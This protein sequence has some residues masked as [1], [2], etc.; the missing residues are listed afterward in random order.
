MTRPQCEP[1]ERHYG[2]LPPRPDHIPRRADTCFRADGRALISLWQLARRG[3]RP[4]CRHSAIACA[5]RSNSGPHQDS[6]RPK[7]QRPPKEET[8]WPR[9]RTTRQ[10]HRTAPRTCQRTDPVQS[11]R[12]AH[13]GLRDRF[14][15]SHSCLDLHVHRHGSAGGGLPRQTGPPGGRCRA[16]ASPSQWRGP[17][18]EVRP[19]LQ[20]NRW[21]GARA[22]CTTTPRPSFQSWR[23]QGTPPVDSPTWMPVPTSSRTM[24]IS[25]RSRCVGPSA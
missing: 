23:R 13:R 19:Q 25:P 10:R 15:N 21:S 5:T 9:R 1:A 16:R 24:A 14:W 18:H 3:P 2:P 6:G 22:L 4:L 8:S 20:G 12:G 11:Q 17:Q 7:R